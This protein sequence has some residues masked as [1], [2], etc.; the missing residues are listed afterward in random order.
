VNEIEALF[1]KYPLEKK[2]WGAENLRPGACNNF[3]RQTLNPMTNAKKVDTNV[4]R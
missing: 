4:K 2:V 3:Q 1:E